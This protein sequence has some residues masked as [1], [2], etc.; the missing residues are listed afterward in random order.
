MVAAYT[1]DGKTN[2]PLTSPAGASTGTEGSLTVRLAVP[3]QAAGSYFLQVSALPPSTK[4]T[5][6]LFLVKFGDEPMPRLLVVTAVAAE[7]EAVLGGPGGGP[8]ELAGLP[9]LRCQTPAGLVDLC[10]GAGPVA[11]AVSTAAVLA[12]PAVAMTWCSRPA[13]PAGSRHRGGLGWPTRSSPIWAPR[14][15]TA[16]SARWPSLVWGRSGRSRSGSLPPGWPS[17]ASAVARC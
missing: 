1:S 9:V 14:R 4:L 15:P 2:T 8:R 11:A 17:A 6:Y 3:A 10:G 13:S 7:A 12:D 5:T 16:A